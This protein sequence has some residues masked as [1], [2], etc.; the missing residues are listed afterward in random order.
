LVSESF[1]SLD[2]V[3]RAIFNVE[4]VQNVLNSSAFV[5]WDVE[6]NGVVV[7]NFTVDEGFTGPVTVDASFSPIAGPVYA[8]TLRVT[9]EVA[10]GQGSITLAFADPF[11]HSLDLSL[12]PAITLEP[13][14]D[15]NTVGDDH[16]VTASLDIGGDPLEGVEVQFEVIDGPNAGEVS[17]P[18]TG[19]C[20]VNDDCA[21]DGAGTV[22]WTYTGD[23]VAGAGTDTIEACFFDEGLERDVCDTATK[24]WVEP[25]P[26]PTSTATGTPEPT[27]TATPAPTPTVLAAVQLPSTGGEPTGG[28]SALSWLAAIAGAIAVMSAGGAWFAY[29][30]RR[31]G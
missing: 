24:E 17:D 8:V 1:T 13:P 6:I 10:G 18:G 30:R 28:A 5:N 21:S 11:A 23:E 20:S 26:T 12:A 31:V 9:N 22:S 15:T 29:Q 4:V 2:S 14:T 25:A 16:A 7:D 19:E 3:D 27:A